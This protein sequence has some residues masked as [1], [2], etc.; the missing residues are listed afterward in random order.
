VFFFMEQGSVG[1]HD[2]CFGQV[3]GDAKKHNLGKD[4]IGTCWVSLPGGRWRKKNRV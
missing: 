3:L 2:R 1:G 4:A